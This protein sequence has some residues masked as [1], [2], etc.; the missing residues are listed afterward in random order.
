MDV[1]QSPRVP[2]GS[3]L[4]TRQPQQRVRIN[5]A[6]LP[7]YTDTLVQT[8]VVWVLWRIPEDSLPFQLCLY[9]F[10]YDSLV[11]THNTWR[12]GQVQLVLT[13]GVSS[14]QGIPDIVGGLG[15][16]MWITCVG[17]VSV[18]KISAAHSGAPDTRLFLTLIRAECWFPLEWNYLCCKWIRYV[19]AF[20][21]MC[22]DP[23]KH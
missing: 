3:L 7:Y 14:C 15:S 17:P 5:K 13:L 22:Q 4:P 20:V 10:F 12:P 1:L 6:L 2:V 9:S 23:K 16:F 11:F 8:K 18:M 21:Y 19:C